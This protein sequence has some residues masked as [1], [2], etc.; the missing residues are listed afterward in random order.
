MLIAQVNR[1]DSVKIFVE[2]QNVSGAKLSVGQ[3]VCFDW[4]NATS[5]GNAV[6]G[7]TASTITL[8][9][10]VMDESLFL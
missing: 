5:H 3:A 1:E 7:P 9:L 2:A 4:R 10:I 8:F 6:A